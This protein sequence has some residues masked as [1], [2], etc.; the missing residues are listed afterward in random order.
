MANHLTLARRIE[1]TA[2]RQRLQR[3]GVQRYEPAWVEIWAFALGLANEAT[4]AWLL[5]AQPMR[6][7]LLLTGAELPALADEPGPGIQ[8]RSAAPPTPEALARLWLWERMATPRLW[9]IQ[10]QDTPPTPLWLPCWLGY[11]TGRQH[12]M[13]VV[14]GLSGEPLPMLKPLV[15]S[16]LKQAHSGPSDSLHQA[17]HARV[18]AKEES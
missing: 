6:R 8:L 4:G 7:A 9:R 16:G 3:L 14:S 17:G 13:I 2:A 18:G 1:D 11:L 10:V 12:R 15:L 5:G